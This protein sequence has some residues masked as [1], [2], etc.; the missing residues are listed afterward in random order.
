MGGPVSIE[1][2]TGRAT[3]A[4][5]GVVQ[6]VLV[7]D[8]HEGF[9]LRTRR[10]LERHRFRVV[11]AANGAAAIHR[12]AA[13][14]PDIVLLDIHLPDMDGFEVAARL[15]AAGTA[16]AILLISTHAEADIADRLGRSAADG[17]V[18]KA[19]LSVATIAARLAR[20]E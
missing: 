18:D 12:A 9:R 11:E 17:F 3:S 1:T 5:I 4:P 15:R 19:D 20:L 10:L 13:D 14:R 2:V 16:G 8:D 7:V 6:T